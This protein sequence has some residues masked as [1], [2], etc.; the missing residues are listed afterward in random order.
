MHSA[1]VACFSNKL[2]SDVQAAYVIPRW[3]KPENAA[4]RVWFR[5]GQLQVVPLPSPK[6]PTIPPFPT[7][8]ETL[9]ILQ[10]GHIK[11]YHSRIEQPIM[12]RL[13]GYP[14]I[15]NQ[16]MHRA[17]VQV[18]ARVAHV[19]KHEPQLVSAAVEAFYYR[20]ACNSH[21]IAHAYT[22]VSS[23]AVLM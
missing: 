12:Q 22:W 10:S 14:G 6:H 1:Y 23:M 15:A 2:L 7:L 16:Q 19:L 21:A 3:L 5:A 9:Q 13:A 20:C 11:T 8:Q 18:P 4:N 17:R